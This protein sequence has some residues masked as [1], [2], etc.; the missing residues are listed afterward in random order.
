MQ[1]PIDGGLE[2]EGKGGEGGD[3][4]GASVSWKDE[5]PVGGQTEEEAGNWSGGGSEEVGGG[6]GGG[7]GGGVW[8]GAS[9]GD[10]GTERQNTGRR[11]RRGL[12][13][14]T[15]KVPSEEY[16]SIMSA[17]A[18]AMSGDVIEVSEGHY[19][20]S[21]SLAAVDVDIVGIG[22]ACNIVIESVSKPV[23]TF[24][25]LKGLVRNVTLRQTGGGC[26]CGVDIAAGALVLENCDISG[27]SDAVIKIHNGGTRASVIG[28]MIHDGTG[29]GILVSSSA[30]PVIINNDI[31]RQQLDGLVITTGAAPTV[32]GNRI[33]A[34][35]TTGI[36][37]KGGGLGLIQ[38][39]DIR[40]NAIAGIVVCDR[41]NPRV[42]NNHVREGEGKGIDV[43]DKGLGYFEANQVA[44]NAMD[45]V[46]VG[47]GVRGVGVRRERLV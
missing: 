3:G 34:C 12:D 30:Q 21:I 5:E 2:G 7:G 43:Y 38:N 37:V 4:G 24:R 44:H 22:Q 29:A 36:L 28:N 6:G 10:M 47:V 1:M 42:L 45:G 31:C 17:V 41:G 15:F 32:D 9:E 40:G 23:L 27:Q 46:S 20:E 35:K 16:A 11:E 8:S 39:N 14:C 25:A 18:A 26:E 19:L 33:Y 13:R